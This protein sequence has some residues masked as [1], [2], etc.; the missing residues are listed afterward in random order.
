MVENGKMLKNGGTWSKWCTEHGPEWWETWFVES[1]VSVIPGDSLASSD[2]V[3]SGVCVE[4]YDSVESCYYSDEPGESVEWGDPVQFGDL[5]E[6]GDSLYLVIML[7]LAILF[8]LVVLL[9]LGNS[10]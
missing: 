3:D 1:G 8:S 9:N 6:S 7:N 4:Y 10:V 5:V 2:P